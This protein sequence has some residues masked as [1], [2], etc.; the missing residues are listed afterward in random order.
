LRRLA[1]LAAFAS[2]LWA[3]DADTFL[4]RNVDLYPVTSEPVKGGAI[5]VVDGRIADAGT[6]V[7]P[8][9][10]VRVI[11]GKGLRAYPGMIDS[12]TELGLA[13]ISD[14]RATVD[15]AELGI[16]MPQLRA[17]IAINAESEHFPVARANG[18]T[19]VLTFPSSSGNNRP[20]GERQIITGQAALIHMDGWTWEEM[21]VSRSAALHLIFPALPSN[22]ASGYAEAKK[23]YDRELQQIDDFFDQARRYQIAKAAARPGFKTDLKMESMLPVLEGKL[24]VA[25]SAS[26]E[27]AIRDAIQFADRQKIR[28][29][30]LHPRELGKLAPDLKSRNIPVI[31]GPTL[32]LPLNEDDAYD[33]A[34]TMPAEA[35][36]AGLKIAF[37]TF[38]NEFVRNL[39]YNAATAVAFGLP[40]DV[41]LKAVTINAAEIWGVTD[42]VG[43]LEKGKWADLMLTNG[44]PFET[45]T[46]VKA[47]FIKG[48]AV[49]LTNRHTRLYEKYLNR[50]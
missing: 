47:L 3:G 24:P 33:S 29:V 14:V 6:K 36:N 4:I 10:G 12:G 30:L 23:A 39:P 18:I 19:S 46:E 17:L 40:Y 44:D 20:S 28:M 13:E 42:Q 45:Q 27:P 41:A 48:K 43:S 16:F 26:R 50:P 21:A 2:G 22:Q 8:A 5:L 9:K 1:L 31:L 32:D 7:A 38:D 35:F 25:I 34:F 37:G 15:T 49:D 11:D